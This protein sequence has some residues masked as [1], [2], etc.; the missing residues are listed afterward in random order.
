MASGDVVRLRAAVALIGPFPALAG[1]DLSVDRGEVVLLQGPNGAGKTTILRV[2][3]G[4][5]PVVSGEVVVLGHDLVADHRAVRRHVGLLHQV[6]GLYDDL[7]VADNVR[8][9]V[10]ATGGD[11]RTVGPALERLGLEGRLARTAVSRLST[12]QRRRAALAVFVA[13]S[14]ALWLLDEPHA[15]LDAE[16]RDLLDGLVA[17]AVGVGATVVLASHELDRASAIAHR[18]VTVSGGRVLSTPAAAGTG[19]AV[20]ARGPAVAE[21]PAAAPAVATPDAEA[22][23]APDAEAPAAP[24]AAARSDE[25]PAHV[26]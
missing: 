2:C 16:G 4:L 20:A 21:G 26:A 22:P 8:F 12:G 13:R 23:A 11:V 1:A 19:A 18:T 9:A 3:A 5:V 14:P 17:E 25:V 6:G 24:D 15:G 7:T 10:R